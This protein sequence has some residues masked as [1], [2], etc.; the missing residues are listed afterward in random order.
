MKTIQRSFLIL[1]V[2][3]LFVACNQMSNKTQ[4]SA[5]DIKNYLAVIASDSLQGRNLLRLVK[6]E[7]SAICQMNLKNLVLNQAITAV[8][9]R[10][11]RW[12]K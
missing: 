3:L 8:I 12:L 9:S 6:Q 10:M 2:T 5:D 11:C 1:P 7:R 4:V